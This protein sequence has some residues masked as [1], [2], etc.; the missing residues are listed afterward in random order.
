M[1]R[2][3]AFAMFTPLLL[4]FSSFSFAQTSPGKPDPDFRITHG[5]VERRTT[6]IDYSL[7]DGSTTVD[8]VAT[9]LLP[10]ATGKAQIRVSNGYAQVDTEF[11]HFEPAT[12]FGPE[13]L[14]YVLWAISPEDQT[15]KLGEILLNAGKGSLTAVSSFNAFGL[16]VTAEP[17]S[18]VSQPNDVVVLEHSTRADRRIP[19]NPIETRF[20]LVARGQYARNALPEDLKSNLFGD[21]IPLGLRE[22]RNAIRIARWSGANQYAADLYANARELLYQAELSRMQQQLKLM[23][24][25]SRQAAH[26][27]EDSRLFS[28]KRLDE[29]RATAQIN[30]VALQLTKEQEAVERTKAEQVRSNQ[31][32]N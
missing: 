23:A 21:E 14:T 28:L 22:A 4:T 15:E 24:M 25:L 7:R 11:E 12:R 20:E 13:Y 8:F 1:K 27:A 18:E 31:T 29:V 3:R 5:L 2:T 16:V 10:K 32:Q 9:P 26:A 30:A 19:F 17:Y 6:A